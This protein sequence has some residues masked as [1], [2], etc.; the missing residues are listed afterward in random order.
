MNICRYNTD[1]G[2]VSSR[3][4]IEIQSLVFFAAAV[5]YATVAMADTRNRKGGERVV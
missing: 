3:R 2:A 5:Q 4:R 1:R